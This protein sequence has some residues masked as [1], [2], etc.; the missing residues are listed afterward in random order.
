[1]LTV[2]VFMFARGC[3]VGDAV[4]IGAISVLFIKHYYQMSF[5]QLLLLGCSAVLVVI[6]IASQGDKCKVPP[7]PRRSNGMLVNHEN[8]IY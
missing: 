6:G 1:M 8:D 5:E 3:G 7:P 4:F 2:D